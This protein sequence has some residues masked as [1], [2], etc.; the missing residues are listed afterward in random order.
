MKKKLVCPICGS[1]KNETFMAQPGYPLVRCLSCS[2]SWDYQVGNENVAQYEK[3]YF[4]NDNPKGGYANYFDGMAINKKTFGDRLKKIENKLGK[5]GKLLDV[6][7]ALGDCLMMAKDLGWKEAEGIELS[8]Y[9]AG[10]AKKRGLKV[11]QG[12]LQSHKY[13]ANSFD[14]VTMFDVIEHVDNP[15]TQFK[16]IKRILKPKGILL[17]VTPDIGGFWS[18]FL[19]SNWYHYKPGEHLLYFSQKSIEKALAKSGFGNIKSYK[20]YHVMSLGYIFNRLRF[21]S[22]KLFGGLLNIVNNS[23]MK[24]I[25]FRVYAGELEAWATKTK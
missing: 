7:C 18:K 24:N 23:N 16:E 1:S 10:F 9:A 11:I 2:M 13:P 3:L 21:Y 6:G 15:M 14:V 19:K 22:P 20:T 4:K 17:L 12:T 5:K 25:P 8:K